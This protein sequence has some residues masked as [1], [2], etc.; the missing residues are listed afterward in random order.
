MLSELDVLIDLAV[1]IADVGANRNQSRSQKQSRVPLHFSA[2]A[3]MASNKRPAS[4]RWTAQEDDYLRKY[5]GH[6]TDQ[7]MA[8]ALG[9]TVA[10]VKL[11]RKREL[12][13]PAPSKAAGFLT[14]QKAAQMVGLDQHRITHWCDEGLIPHRVMPG[15]RRVR[16]IKL[17]TFKRWMV[18]PDNWIYF[19][20]RKL[21]PGPIRRLCELRAERWGDEWWTSVEVARHHGVE[22]NDVARLCKQG[23]LAGAQPAVSRSGR[24]KNRVWAN[25]YVRRS[26]ALK[27]R[28][29]KRAQE[30]W[31]PTPRALEWMLKARGMGW[32]YTA[33]ARSMGNPIGAET[34]RKRIMN[35][36]SK[37]S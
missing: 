37:N 4:A 28:F 5:N 31:Q 29:Y 16:Q 26:N 35:E 6:Q 32:S 20:W 19:D 27:A 36:C 9:R 17:V 12:R 3:Q 33:I 23:R 30:T 13:L 2:S 18:N 25:W 34:I 15:E 10:S 7:E 1:N 22:T 24:H 8:A 11:R 21:K 14:A